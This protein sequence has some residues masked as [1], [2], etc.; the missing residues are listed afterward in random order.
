MGC[1]GWKASDGE[2]PADPAPPPLPIEVL[3]HHRA[4]AESALNAATG[5]R[6]LC[7]ISDITDVSRP[8]FAEGGLAAVREFQRKRS[9]E[10]DTDTLTIAGDLLATWEIE[11][12]ASET[13]GPTWAAYRNGGVARLRAIIADLGTPA[14]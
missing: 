9:G 7:R 11:R 5:G 2:E 14:P 13:L 6:P 3:D 4:L 1:C 8:K 10:A 12:Q